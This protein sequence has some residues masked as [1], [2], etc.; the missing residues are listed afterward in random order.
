MTFRNR[1]DVAPD[2][3]LSGFETSVS[4][5]RVADLVRI[6]GEVRGGKL[7]VR[8]GTRNGGEAPPLAE[9]AALEQSFELQEEQLYL[10]GIAPRPRLAQLKLGQT[11]TFRSFAPF[12]PGAPAQVMQARVDRQ[13]LLMWNAEPMIVFVVEIRDEGGAGLSTAR[14]PLARLWVNEQGEVLQT[15]TALMGL[16]FRFVRQPGGSYDD[17]LPLVNAK[18]FP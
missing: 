5:V 1:I 2:G 7:H 6:Q 11:W 18:E 15:E 10:D 3:R 17:K 16:K 9:G 14:D 12:P 4:A 8:A 13:D